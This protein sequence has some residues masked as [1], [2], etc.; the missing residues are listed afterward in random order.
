MR[1]KLF[2]PIPT[3][4]IA[5]TEKR[6]MVF[7][8]E[9][10]KVAGNDGSRE[11]RRLRTEKLLRR[12]RRRNTNALPYSIRNFRPVSGFQS[13]MVYR[14]GST[15]VLG[16]R[17]LR[18]SGGSGGNLWSYADTLVFHHAGLVIDLRSS[19][20]RRETDARRWMTEASKEEQQ[21]GPEPCLRPRAIRLI[22]IPVAGTSGGK[23]FP[24]TAD[25]FGVE[26]I[27]VEASRYVV[28]LDV[29]NRSE[30]LRY[31]REQWLGSEANRSAVVEENTIDDNNQIMN[32]LNKRG[33]TG[34]NE[35]IL[36]TQSGQRGM[37]L[38][39]QLMTLYKE[40]AAA[41]AAVVAKDIQ[42]RSSNDASIV[43]HCVQGKDRTGILSMLMQLL[44]GCSDEVIVEDYHRSNA[45][46]TG[47]AAAAA[48]GGGTAKEEVSSAAAALAMVGT[49]GNRDNSPRSGSMNSQ[50]GPNHR[51][52]VVRMDKVVFRGTNRR[53]MVS[54]LE[55]LRLR[56][57]S[58]N[59]YFDA[60]GFDES[61]RKRFVNVFVNDGTN[62]NYGAGEEKDRLGARGAR[63]IHPM[64][65]L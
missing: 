58:S 8:D 40:E 14:S 33:L 30:L 60:I 42:Q 43:F 23:T 25:L 21:H 53:A 4:P 56:H 52:V 50:R 27:D 18:G 29:L 59:G 44:M 15:D 3:S 26:G 49:E 54:T 19:P 24:T 16:A 6:R 55:G 20:E 2:L 11:R 64:S 1:Q 37:C 39:L 31:A 51:S 10:P 57:G 63:T 13:S 46:F 9:Q 22:E 61:W 35:A 17:I 62:S 47:T 7:R 41:R 28:R 5:S 32:D 45:E 65:R 34:L 36:E 38:A 12:K 48:G